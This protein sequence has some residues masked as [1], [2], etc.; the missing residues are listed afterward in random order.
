MP[1]YSGYPPYRNT[2]RPR[3]GGH[4]FAE[5]PGIEIPRSTFD[6]SSG[7]TTGFLA[8]LLIPIFVDEVLPGD[9]FKLNMSSFVR[10][11][12]PLFPVFDNI[13]ADYFFF[14]VPNRL[15]WQNWHKFLGE[16][17]NPGDST[18]FLVPQFTA[19]IPAEGSLSDYMG[20]PLGNPAMAAITHNTLWHRAYNLIWNEW[21]R[22]ENLQDRVVVDVDDG[23]DLIA[24]Y[25]Q[26][27]RR[28]KR[29][30]YF[31]S[32]LP[33]PQKGDPVLLPLGSFAPV[34]V[35]TATP[36]P[37]FQSHP[38]NANLGAAQMLAGQTDLE[39]VTGNVTG[40][41][42][43]WKFNNSG[44]RVNLASATSATINQIREAF[45]VQKLL[46]RDARGGTR[47]VELVK[48][49][50]GVT[51]PDFRVQ[52]PEYLGGGSAPVAIH[53]VARTTSMSASGSSGLPAYA[54]LGGFGTHD[55]RNIGFV[56]SFVEHGVIIGMV[57][58]R[59]D[60]RYQQGLN[61]MWSRQDR[62]DFYWPE[63][64]HLGEQEVLS[65]EIYMDGSV[66][67]TDVFG[68]QERWAEYRYKP[69]IITGRMR[70]TSVA[71][72]DA[73]HLAQEFAARPLLNDVF[74]EENPPF[75]RI[76]AVLSEISFFGDFWFSLHCARPMPTFSV[77]GFV[78]HF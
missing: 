77:P 70:S 55:A 23:P 48:A 22:D 69:G 16:Q 25:T 59:A 45:Q 26:P 17:E 74:I 39:V 36:V 76:Q 9:T 63:L 71:T 15:V 43:S 41:A 1:S 49:H 40:A 61:R 6:R 7:H 11:A 67:D 64:A 10:M 58:V 5:V 12:T 20:I 66:D 32:A 46:E 28:G 31:T 18:S 50:F 30:D 73:W 34:V 4:S 62:Y 8:G 3:V 53:P 27:L 37:T 57:C 33:F 75:D 72:L 47:L 29:H 2:G 56:K 44:L 14:Y 35:D 52:R 68:Y 51:I 65:K 24:D 60:L 38:A 13:T 42:V 78:D 54:A 21:F 19:Y